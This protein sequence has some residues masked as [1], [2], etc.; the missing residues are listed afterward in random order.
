MPSAIFL[1]LLADPSLMAEHQHTWVLM[2]RGRDTA[3]YLCECGETDVI[4]DEDLEVDW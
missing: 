4:D 1:L 3:H 2:G